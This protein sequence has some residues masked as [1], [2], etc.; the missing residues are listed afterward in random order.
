MI[1]LK[2][3]FTGST[4]HFTRNDLRT[5]KIIVESEKELKETNNLLSKTPYMRKKEDIMDVFVDKFYD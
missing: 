4:V 5:L 3:V 2:R 1:L